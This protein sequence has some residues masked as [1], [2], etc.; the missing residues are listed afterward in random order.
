MSAQNDFY[1][2]RFKVASR[3]YTTGRPAY[4]KALS[5]RVA[6]L[7]ALE[8]NAD[9]LDVGTG[10]GFLAIDFAP[11]AR[12][13]KALDP[14]AEMLAI[15]REN[16][17]RAGV[18]IEFIS[19]SS[20]DLGPHLGTFRL[21]TFGRSFHWTSRAETLRTLDRLVVKGGAVSLYSDGFPDVP[22]N[23]WHSRYAEILDRY[24]RD[25][26]ARKVHDAVRNETILL[27]SPFNHLECVSVFERR[28]TPFEYF[29]DRAL[30]YGKSWHD[31]D[32]AHRQA[33]L[34]EIRV[35]LDGYVREDGT[36]EEVVEGRALIAWRS[37]EA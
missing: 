23:A 8:G 1:P 7:L 19:G 16:A 12:A 25:D 29:L 5:A 17:Q 26:P 34:D 21:V 6:A 28:S 35:A 24:G 11:Y 9:V 4:P 27:D 15:A 3:Y 31:P 32:D 36:V 33:M 2:D 10:P 20:H 18:D 37:G 13:V 22:Q 30:S 14:S